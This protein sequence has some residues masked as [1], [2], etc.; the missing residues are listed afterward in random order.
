MSG[1]GLGLRPA[2]RLANADLPTY[3]SPR[4]VILRFG[5]GSGIEKGGLSAALENVVKS[6]KPTKTLLNN[7]IILRLFSPQSMN[8][9]G[10]EEYWALPN[11]FVFQCLTVFNSL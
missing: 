7:N 8:P 6:K 10:V 11:D 4:M 2:S 9:G 5:G 3:M 1:L